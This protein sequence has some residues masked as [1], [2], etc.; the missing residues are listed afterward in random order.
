MVNDYVF[1]G[2]NFILDWMRAFIPRVHNI[3][4]GLS[5][6]VYVLCTLVYCTGSI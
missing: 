5:T 3:E 1:Q 4:K 6:L 2:E